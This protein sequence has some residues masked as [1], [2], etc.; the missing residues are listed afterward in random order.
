MT[1][2]RAVSPTEEARHAIL[3][4]RDM[5]AHDFD[6]YRQELN[7]HIDAAGAELEELTV[8]RGTVNDAFEHAISLVQIRLDSLQAA[9][10]TVL[11]A[12]GEDSPPVPQPKMARRDLG[13]IPG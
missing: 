10:G 12:I 1:Q 9:R 4:R 8:N 7:R 3:E 2:A 11:Q 6:A 13:G 5:V